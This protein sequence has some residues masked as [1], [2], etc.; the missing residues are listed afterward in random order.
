MLRPG[1]QVRDHGVAADNI[2]RGRL[3]RGLPL[4]GLALRQGLGRIRDE[5]QK[6][7]RFTREAER[8]VAVLGDMKGR[9]HEGQLVLPR[10]R[11][12]PEQHRAA[13]Q[14]I[15]GALQADAPPMPFETL[16]DDIERELQRPVDKTFAWIGEQPMAA[17][18]RRTSRTLPTVLS[19]GPGQTQP[20]YS[21][22]AA[23]QPHTRQAL[24]R[25]STSARVL[26]PGSALA[27]TEQI[28][29]FVACQGRGRARLLAGV[30][31]PRPARWGR[32]CGFQPSE[33]RRCVH[34]RAASSC[35]ASDQRE[36]VVVAADELHCER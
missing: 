3:A 4:A 24:P 26:G 35:A 25:P 32:T 10:R 34:G 14:Q 2:R 9:C 36:F 20:V 27:S 6:L 29:D 22:G 5:H 13:Y 23:D 1:H 28:A 7:D 30:A 33:G 18:T 15:I 12:H 19:P 16:R 11:C 8:Y 21:L 17:V 31:C